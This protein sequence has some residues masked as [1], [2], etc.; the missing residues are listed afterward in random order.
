MSRVI[1]ER[2]VFQTKGATR[3]LLPFL[4][5]SLP[6][7]DTSDKRR[8]EEFVEGDE[9]Q[10]QFV[11]WVTGHKLLSLLQ[12]NKLYTQNT[13]THHFCFHHNYLFSLFHLYQSLLRTVNYGPV[14]LVL[15]FF[16]GWLV[17][18]DRR[19]I[20]VM[21]EWIKELK[22]EVNVLTN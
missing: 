7:K 11:I 15:F 14:N 18:C 6:S 1:G 10:L 20:G 17:V 12:E 3:V 8:T 22:R 16:F 13:H 9:K 19:G 2:R 5:S 21:N 4:C